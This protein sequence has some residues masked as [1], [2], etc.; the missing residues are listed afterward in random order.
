M[1]YTVKWTTPEN[2]DGQVGCVN[3]DVADNVARYIHNNQDTAKIT[4]TNDETNEKI[5][6]YTQ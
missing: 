3:K 6:A 2:T 5:L 4:V 1:H